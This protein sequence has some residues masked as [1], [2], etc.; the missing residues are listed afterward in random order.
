MADSAT[1]ILLVEDDPGDV[2]LIR[3]ALKGFKTPF[4]LKVVGDGEEAMA[5]LRK[6][7]RFAAEPTPDL[8]LLD[9]N[10]PRKNGREL[11][12]EIRAEPALSRVPIAVLTTSSSDQD[13]IDGYD[14]RLNRYVT[15]PMRLA[16]LNEA[17]MDIE[18]F[19]R[20]AAA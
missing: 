17:V 1:R 20:Q 7:G 2:R 4:E 15:K 16:A 9:L 10:L 12:S 5:Y 8:I 3:E 6:E 13:L 18:S 11:F 14:P 19:W